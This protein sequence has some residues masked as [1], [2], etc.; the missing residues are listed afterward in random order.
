MRKRKPN[1]N[2][3]KNYCAALPPHPPPPCFAPTSSC[4]CSCVCVGLLKHPF[5]VTSHLSYPPQ[6]KQTATGNRPKQKKAARRLDPYR[7]HPTCRGRGGAG[8]ASEEHGKGRHFIKGEK[9]E[10]RERGVEGAKTAACVRCAV[11]S[12]SI[13]GFRPSHLLLPRLPVI[14]SQP[15]SAREG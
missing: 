4:P 5:D 10:G 13:T 8:G 14:R 15:S 12:P 3:K 1:N 9:E 7:L 2:N 11:D 6:Q